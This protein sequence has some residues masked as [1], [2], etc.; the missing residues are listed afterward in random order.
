MLIAFVISLPQALHSLK[1]FSESTRILLITYQS[2]PH[3]DLLKFFVPTFNLI[4][5]SLDEFRPYIGIV[6]LFFAIAGFYYVIKKRIIDSG[7]IEEAKRVREESEKL[8]K[9][10]QVILKSKK[11]LKELSPQIR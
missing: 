9:Y 1:F 5:V 2:A 3:I 10:K 4:D 8:K 7:L 6:P 11:W